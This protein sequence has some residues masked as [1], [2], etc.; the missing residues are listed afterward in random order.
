[1]VQWTRETFGAYTEALAKAFGVRA[2]GQCR[3]RGYVPPY[4][5]PTSRHYDCLARDF[6]GPHERLVALEEWAD[7]TGAFPEVLYRG[8]AGHGPG[9]G[10]TRH[11]HLGVDPTGDAPAPPGGDYV[12][13]RTGLL[14]GLLDGPVSAAQDLVSGALGGIRDIGLTVG[15]VAA[16][17]ALVILGAYRATK[18]RP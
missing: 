1:M 6:T 2:A 7:A 13:S 8:V 17:A 4:G 3:E 11:L 9:M 18:G 15:F 10:G 16:G 14:D 12:I 5:S